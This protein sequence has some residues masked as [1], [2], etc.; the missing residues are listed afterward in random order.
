MLGTVCRQFWF[1]E[2][3]FIWVLPLTEC[4]EKFHHCT[5]ELAISHEVSQSILLPFSLTP[6]LSL[7]C[8]KLL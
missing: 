1:R 6:I 2:G 7:F 3:W 4:N 8:Q 5:L